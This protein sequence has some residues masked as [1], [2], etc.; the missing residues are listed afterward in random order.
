MH[1]LL[2]N[3]NYLGGGGGR[4][5][6]LSLGVVLYTYLTLNNIQPRG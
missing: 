1:V 2:K 3:R 4:I 5:S 6:N